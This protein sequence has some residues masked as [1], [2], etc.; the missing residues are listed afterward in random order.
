MRGSLKSPCPI[1]V[2]KMNTPSS[3]NHNADA[4]V[5]RGI[6]GFSYVEIALAI[7]IWST[8]EIAAKLAQSQVPPLNIAT[9]RFWVG[10]LSLF[11]LIVVS[12]NLKT[13]KKALVN[14]WKELLLLGISGITIS[15]GLIHISVNLTD[16]FVASSI[17]STSP[18]FVLLISIF[19]ITNG[20]KPQKYEWVG[21]ALGAIGVIL[22]GFPK[23]QGGFSTNYLL[24]NL[25]ALIASISFGFYTWLGIKITK[26]YGGILTTFISVTIGSL[27][28]IPITLFLE[29][30]QLSNATPTD[31]I[32]IIWLGIIVVTLAYTLYFEG[33]KNANRFIGTSLYFL[34]PPLATI[35]ASIFLH[36]MPTPIEYVGVAIISSSFLIMGLGYWL[37]T[38]KKRKY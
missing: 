33:L 1:T 21:I 17:L 34:K 12:G 10:S 28:L 5:S 9:T 24:G 22:F 2:E 36:E 32:Y 4:L 27:F 37:S 16:A 26:E 13:L 25:L 23:T 30:Y 18:L 8:S 20:L 3:N 14:H 29:G 35:W 15:F 11:L 19:T 7:I 31:W 6:K 38:I